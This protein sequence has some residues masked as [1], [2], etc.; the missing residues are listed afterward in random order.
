MFND[1]EKDLP[2]ELMTSEGSWGLSTDHIGPSS[3]KPPAPQGPGPGGPLQNG[4]AQQDGQQ[5]SNAALRQ[6]IQ[7]NHHLQNLQQVKIQLNPPSNLILILCLIVLGKR[8]SW[9]SFISG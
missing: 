4:V 7:L 3:S 2:D 8:F 5:I 1:L 9:Q 6:Q